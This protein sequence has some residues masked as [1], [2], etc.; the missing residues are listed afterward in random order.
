V[1]QRYQNR[2]VET[3]CIRAMRGLLPKRRVEG[4]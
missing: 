3:I 2:E 4:K 1:Y